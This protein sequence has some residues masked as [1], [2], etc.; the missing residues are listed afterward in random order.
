L[1]R[2]EGYAWGRERVQFTSLPRH[3]GLEPVR[4]EFRAPWSRSLRLVS[5][6]TVALLA[7]LVALGLTTGPRQLWIWNLAMVG[8]PLAVLI[9]SLPFLVRGYVLTEGDLTVRRLLWDTHVSLA[10][11][12]SAAGVPEGLKGSVRLLGNGGLFS[13]TGWYW[14]RRLGRFRAWAT[15]PDRVVLLRFED[16]RRVVITPDDV[17]HFLVQVRQ[18]AASHAQQLAGA[19]APD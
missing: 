16:G 6:G 10:G 5:G 8:L 15:D 19:R 9:T 13:I 7:T 11:L 12:Q 1:A 3:R 2:R 17:Q 14:N 18:S 4:F